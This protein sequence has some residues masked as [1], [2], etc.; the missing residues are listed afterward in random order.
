MIT[1]VIYVCTYV[2]VYPCVYIYIDIYIYKAVPGDQFAVKTISVSYTF[3][4]I[5]IYIYI[6]TNM[7]IYIYIQYLTQNSYL[8]CIL[9]HRCVWISLSCGEPVP[10]EDHVEVVM[11]VSIYIYIYIEREI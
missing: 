7:C 11:R 10:R 1:I 4:P 2:Y 3:P 5:N 8:Y 6:Y 9:N